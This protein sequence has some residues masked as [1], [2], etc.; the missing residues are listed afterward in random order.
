VEIHDFRIA[1][2]R[3]FLAHARNRDPAALAPDVLV[4]EDAELRRCLAWALDVVD[5][6]AD[7]ELNENV[8]QVTLWGGLYITPADVASLCGGCLTRLIGKQQPR[9]KRVRASVSPGSRKIA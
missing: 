1:H 5:D 9:A 6:F 4:R 3:Q 7:T 8:T 2:A